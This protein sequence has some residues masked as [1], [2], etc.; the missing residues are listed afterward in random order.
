MFTTTRPFSASGAPSYTGTSPEPLEKPPPYTYT[1]TGRRSFAREAVHT[2]RK[3]QF[4]LTGPRR[5]NSAVHGPN[6]V[7]GPCMHDG[8][9]CSAERTFAHATGGAGARQR[10]SPTG[11]AA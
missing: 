4:S 11:G 9:N 5:R 8:P 3:R 1:S 10:R 6:G 2:L 7:F